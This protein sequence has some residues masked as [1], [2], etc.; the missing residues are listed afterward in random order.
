MSFEALFWWSAYGVLSLSLA[1]ALWRLA[2]GPL[3]VDRIVA[4]DLIAVIIMAA[5]VL[6]AIEVNQPLLLNVSL[7]LAVIV[8]FGTVAVARFLERETLSC[9]TSSS[10]S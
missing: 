5:L 3:L 2:R 4:L 10:S 7:A 1:G 8:F 6:R 9:K